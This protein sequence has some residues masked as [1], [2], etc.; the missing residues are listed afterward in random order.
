MEFLI[1][2]KALPVA[3]TA[4]DEANAALPL[5]A[6]PAAMPIILHS[7]IPALKCLSGHTFLAS[8]V[9]VDLVKSAS[10]HSRHFHFLFN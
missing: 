5:A 9:L 4:N 8:I 1:I 7:A 10:K 6:R 2:S 3:N